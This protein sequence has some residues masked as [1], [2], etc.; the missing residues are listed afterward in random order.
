MTFAFGMKHL[1]LLV[2]GIA[3][4]IG[5]VMGVSL[6]VISFVNAGCHIQRHG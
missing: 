6:T 4:G 3:A 5:L 2:G 1:G